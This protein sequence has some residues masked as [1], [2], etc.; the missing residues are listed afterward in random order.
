MILFSGSACTTL[1][2]PRSWNVLG[3]ETARILRYRTPRVVGVESLTLKQM[4][5]VNRRY[6]RKD[7]PTDVLSF[8]AS[9]HTPKQAH[10]PLD[11]GDI[12]LCAAYARTEASRRGISQEEELARLVIHGVLHLAGYDHATKRE[13]AIMFKKQETCLE[14]V[15]LLMR[16]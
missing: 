7:H 9:V 11:M 5:D 15:L 1:L 10:E 8:A 13:E 16:V 14:R 6:R 4:Q 3:K 2:S 12:L